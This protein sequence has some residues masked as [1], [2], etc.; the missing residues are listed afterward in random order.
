[1]RYEEFS[2]YC[3]AADGLADEAAHE[4]ER[5]VL[6]WCSQNPN[7]SVAE[8]R[9]AAKGIMAGF[10]QTYGE[11]AATLAAQWYDGLAETAGVAVPAAVSDAGTSRVRE[12]VDRVARYQAG[13]LVGG[14]TAGFARACGEYA[15]NAVT[16]SLNESI[17]TNARRDKRKGVRFARIP[18][19]GEA[20]A[21]CLMLAGRGAVY[22]T[23][24]TAGEFSHY[25]RNCRC[26]VVPGFSDNPDAELVEGFNPAA[27][28]DRIGQIEEET[29]LS[30]ASGADAAR[31]SAD[32]RLRSEQWLLGGAAPSV[33]FAEEILNGSYKHP[34][35][36]EVDA[37]AILAAHGYRA[38]FV[39]D[40]RELP[41]GRCIGL[42]DLES[43]VELKSLINAKSVSAIDRHLRDAS[44]KQG[45]SLCVIDNSKGI[46]DDDEC[47]KKIVEKMAK[48]HV[49]DALLITSGGACKRIWT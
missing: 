38:H 40:R 9:E 36:H 13:K 5:Q 41:D 26:R 43:G 17:M 49:K 14:D 31:L 29:G 28:R 32:L 1:M 2:A 47:E 33:T 20:C 46:L 34:E 42:P 4:V 35:P 25:H 8:C 19:D 44:E 23:S 22:H 6:A 45:L 16:V 3:K 39:K 30:F 12:T 21:F 10:V 15:S 18:S 11:A 37:A 7:A 48:R 27:L 24:R